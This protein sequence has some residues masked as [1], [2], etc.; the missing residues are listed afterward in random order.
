MFETIISKILVVFLFIVTSLCLNVYS[1]QPAATT[2]PAGPIVK[3]P[4][5]VI[6]SNKQSIDAIKKEDIQVFE[7]KA[8]QKVLS[9]E[10]DERPI[11]I[12]IAIDSTG[13]FRDLLPYA[14]EA[15]KMVINDRRPKDEIFLE[16]FVSSDK[17]RTI[18][19]FTTDR[20]ALLLSLLRFRVEGGQ[21]AVLDAVYM[22]GDHLSKHTPEEDRR[23]V[24]VIITDGE[25]RNSYYKTEDVINLLHEKGVQV[26]S[27]AITT[28]L[29][30]ES[31]F[32]R[33]SPKER[34]EKLLKKLADETG[35]RVV[36]SKT[37]KQLAEGT[38]EVIRSLRTSFRLTFQSSNT[39]AIKGFRRVEVKQIPSSDKRTSI[40]APG[41]FFNPTASLSNRNPSNKD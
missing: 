35:G 31:G 39:S 27:L 3:L 15:A 14:I 9:I 30:G 11:D 20:S 29:D 38:E 24:L 36:Y 22:A 12:A 13:S 16:S 7:N 5:I 19:E 1:Q 25:D 21:S 41:Y 10:R 33:Q 32:I 26:F 40:S 28:K 23:K 37:P 18:Q 2:E 34:A 4:L 6:D 17:I 8:E